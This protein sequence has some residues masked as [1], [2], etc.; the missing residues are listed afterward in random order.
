[1]AG[2]IADFSL[3]LA[4]SHLH[5]GLVVVNGNKFITGVVVTGADH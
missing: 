3:S 4:A 1:M 5:G 2:D